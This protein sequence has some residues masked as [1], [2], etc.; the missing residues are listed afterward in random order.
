MLQDFLSTDTYVNQRSVSYN[1]MSSSPHRILIY[2]LRRDLRLV[3]NPIFH[4]LSRMHSQSQKPFT[5]LIP[6]YVFPAQQ[7]E[8]SGFISGD[9]S[10]PYPPAR[11]QTGSFWRCGA[12]RAKFLAES[13]WDLKQNLEGVGSGMCVRAGM[14]QDVVKHLMEGIEEDGSGPASKGEVTGLWMTEEVAI[15]EK[16]EERA[17]RKVVE[18]K[19]K[20]FK[21]WK[22]EKYFIDE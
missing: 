13:V 17:L 10:S 16:R 15:E 14:V 6:L 11:S 7:V 21:V 1:I 8:V 12:T 5:H 20:E 9:A 18:G 4:E 22:D 2:L 3:D 19:G